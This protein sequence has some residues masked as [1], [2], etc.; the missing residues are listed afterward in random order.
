MYDKASNS[1]AYT[2]EAFIYLYLSKDKGVLIYLYKVLD[3]ERR[4]YM[5]K[6]KI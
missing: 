1:V 5:P 4:L 6:S 3:A 2:L